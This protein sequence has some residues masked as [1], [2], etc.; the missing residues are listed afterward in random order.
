MPPIA[1]VCLMPFCLVTPADDS[2]LPEVE[3]DAEEQ[4]A[5]QQQQHYAQQEQQQEHQQHAQQQQH[6]AHQQQQPAAGN[7]GKRGPSALGLQLHVGS[8][9]ETGEWKSNGI[10]VKKEKQAQAVPSNLQVI[11]A[12]DLVK[13]WLR[14]RCCLVALSAHSVAQQTTCA[15]IRGSTAAASAA[16]AP[17]QG[18]ETGASTQ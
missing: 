1:T 7:A 5:Q 2:T 14:C 8:Q 6:E 9:M 12:D 3:E 15:G 11:P 16:P 10:W 4:A 18:L 17:S 13:V